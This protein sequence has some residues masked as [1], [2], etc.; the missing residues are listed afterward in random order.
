VLNDSRTFYSNGATIT[1]NLEPTLLVSFSTVEYVPVFSADT[2]SPYEPDS[3]IEPI[4][5]IDIQ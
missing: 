4:A 5:E 3:V 1:L 2:G